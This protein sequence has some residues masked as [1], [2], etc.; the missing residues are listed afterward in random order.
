MGI[1]RLEVHDNVLCMV[2]SA[3][4]PFEGHFDPR[5][6]INWELKVDKEFEEYDLSEKQM[7]FAASNAFN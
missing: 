1:Q 7:V 6:Y 2:S 4:P 5:A 3:I